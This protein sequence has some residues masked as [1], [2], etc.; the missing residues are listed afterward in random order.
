MIAAFLRIKLYTFIDMTHKL[1]LTIVEYTTVLYFTV[2]PHG[3]LIFLGNRLNFRI[4]FL[5]RRKE[6]LKI[7]HPWIIY[8]YT[9]HV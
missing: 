4:S 3:S 9:V 7:I 6:T 1:L 5:V 8:E 2:L